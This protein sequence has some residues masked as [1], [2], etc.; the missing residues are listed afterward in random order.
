MSLE[1]TLV[2]GLGVSGKAALEYLLKNG[3]S[4][5]GVDRSLIQKTVEENLTLS[6]ENVSLD[7]VRELILSPGIP[8]SH[9]LV[10]E[11]KSL[12][13]PVLKE[14]EFAL[15]R[16][17]NRCIGVTASVGKT[18]TVSMIVHVLNFHRIK[19][20][21]L[22]NIGD[23]LSSYLLN[24]DPNEI[25]VVELSSFQLENFSS[26]V[27]DF[28][29]L[30]NIEPNHLDWHSSMD[31]YAKA[32]LNILKSL[33]KGG[34]AY[35]SEKVKQKYGLLEETFEGYL[36][37]EKSQNI[38]AVFAICKEF[39][40]TESKL[41]TA[42][43]TFK[44]PKH[45]MEEIG[46][47]D[48]VLYIDDSKATSV[49]AALYGVSQIT[50]PTILIVGG[51]DKGASYKP[52]IDVFKGKVRKVIAY[53]EAKEKIAK[54]LQDFVDLECIDSFT[55]AVLRARNVSKKGELVLLSPG[56]SSFDQFRSFEE[57]GDVFRQIVKG[58]KWIEKK[59][60]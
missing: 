21:A 42:L 6:G 14:A 60:S 49:E 54:D 35:V 56:C 16:L 26:Q 32:K 5:I 17:R 41:Y 30:L 11:A 46:S 13:I 53:G 51:K 44:K 38:Q 47:F 50:F 27:F 25:L 15:Q 57:R 18:T 45:R 10:Q 24:P 2:L 23:P 28:S 31:L 12:N 8:F 40:I 58:E 9:P 7:G 4:V 20:R 19:A 36:K 3:F 43:K 33:R 52:W 29:L 1:K 37:E 22:G 39:G 48:G 55:D 34:K 59:Q